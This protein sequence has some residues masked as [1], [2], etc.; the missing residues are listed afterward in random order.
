M[1]SALFFTKLS[2]VLTVLYAGMNL[3]QITSSYAYLSEKIE[4]F[5]IVL[6]EG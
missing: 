6:A 3:H 4:Q 1:L 5:R 2:A